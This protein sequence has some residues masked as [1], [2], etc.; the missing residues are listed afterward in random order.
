MFAEVQ[1]LGVQANPI[2]LT[3]EKMRIWT[4]EILSA[5]GGDD[6]TANLLDAFMGDWFRDSLGKCETEEREAADQVQHV[7]EEM[8]RTGELE[9]HMRADGDYDVHLRMMPCGEHAPSGPLVP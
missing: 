5:V 2:K 8:E 6:T 4:L 9:M 1:Q 7:W 3:I